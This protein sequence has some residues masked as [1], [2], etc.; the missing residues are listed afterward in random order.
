MLTYMI[1]LPSSI[2]RAT[3]GSP[4]KLDVTVSQSDTLT[5]QA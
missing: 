2:E 3:I 5:G 4:V 1:G